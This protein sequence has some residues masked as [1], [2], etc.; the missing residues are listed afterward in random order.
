MNLNT[1]PFASKTSTRET[2][3]PPTPFI[4]SIL[5]HNVMQHTWIEK[6][7]ELETDILG[8]VKFEVNKLAEDVVETV[9]K[10]CGP[11]QCQGQQVELLTIRQRGLVLEGKERKLDDEGVGREENKMILSWRQ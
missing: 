9:G 1:L 7:D 4:P 6:D 2:H 11:K 3:S 10:L 5:A 8:D